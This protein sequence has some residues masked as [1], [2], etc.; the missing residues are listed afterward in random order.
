[1]ERE[2]LPACLSVRPPGLADPA[3]GSG[4]SGS[5]ATGVSLLGNL[6]YRQGV[7][8]SH[9]QGDSWEHVSNNVRHVSVGPLDQVWGDGDGRWMLPWG[10]GLGGVWFPFW[11]PPPPLLSPWTLCHEEGE[12]VGFSGS[13]FQVWV[14]ADKVQGSHSLSRG[15]VCRRTG[16][17]SLE[18]KGQGWDY[19]IGVSRHQAAVLAGVSRH[20]GFRWRWALGRAPQGSDLEG[21]SL[22]LDLLVALGDSVLFSQ[23]GW[24]HLSIRASATRAPRSSSQKPASK[25]NGQPP[26]V[27]GGPWQTPGP[28]CC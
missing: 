23:G 22:P 9:P 20:P 26:S 7:T 5:H 10:Q 18:P 6:W 27:A 24:D 21:R 25:Q 4:H 1:M 17:Q 14:I 8:P 13:L 19:G 15:T 12:G 16:V 2:T 11:S 3:G 28:V